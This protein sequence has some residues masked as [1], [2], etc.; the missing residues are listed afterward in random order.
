M[1]QLTA[2]PTP[3]ADLFV[4]RSVEFMSQ[5]IQSFL[6]SNI[7]KGRTDRIWVKY[8]PSP[9][10]TNEPFRHIVFKL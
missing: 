6:D 10:A 3:R 8:A 5:K 2:C 1:H 7:L 9:L 4:C